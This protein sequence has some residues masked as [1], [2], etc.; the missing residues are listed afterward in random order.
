MNNISQIINKPPPILLA[1]S[2]LR[3]KRKILSLGINFD[4]YIYYV[5]Y[6]GMKINQTRFARKKRAHYIHEVFCM[7]NLTVIPYLEPVRRC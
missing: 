6:T 5:P 4:S 7:I 3:T 1:H 2:I